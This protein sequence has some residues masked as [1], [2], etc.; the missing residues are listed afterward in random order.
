MYVYIYMCRLYTYI[1]HV[2]YIWVFP[3]GANIRTKFRKVTKFHWVR[4]VNKHSFQ[5]QGLM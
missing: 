4:Q 3:S 1:Y 5:N 2:R